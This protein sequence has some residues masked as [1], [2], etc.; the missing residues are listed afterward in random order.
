MARITSAMDYVSLASRLFLV[1][2]LFLSAYGKTTY[3]GDRALDP[4]MAET[5][6]VFL[7]IPLDLIHSYVRIL[8]W[9]EGI[10]AVLILVGI[11]TRIVSAVLFLVLIGFIVSNGL[12]LYYGMTD[13]CCCFGDLASM[14]LPVA[15]LLD[16]VMLGATAL[17]LVWGGGKMTLDTRMWRRI[18]EGTQN[19]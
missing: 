5:L 7:F 4:Q 17:L 6:S 16:I 19:V 15:L 3:P 8:P 2:V 1:T 14:R 12:F 9:L 18:R 13:V 11:A 10:L